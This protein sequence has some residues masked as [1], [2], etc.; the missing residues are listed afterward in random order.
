MRTAVMV[1]I[2]EGDTPM[3][4]WIQLIMK[5]GGHHHTLAISWQTACDVQMETGT[6]QTRTTTL[7]R[8]SRTATLMLIAMMD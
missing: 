4:T 7:V 5:T 3:V 2:G 8:Q 6:T 1:S